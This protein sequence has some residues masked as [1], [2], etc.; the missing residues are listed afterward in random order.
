M[1][2]AKWYGKTRYNW[3]K[4]LSGFV[5]DLLPAMSAEDLQAEATDFAH[6]CRAQLWYHQPAAMV[7]A[8][9]LMHI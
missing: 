7:C 8:N 1:Q 2:A 5:R 6:R 9:L 3:V 4:A